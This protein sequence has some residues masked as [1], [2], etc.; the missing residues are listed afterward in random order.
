M[1]LKRPADL[2]LDLKE[3]CIYVDQGKVIHHDFGMSL[4]TRHAKVKLLLGEANLTTWVISSTLSGKS[5]IRQCSYYGE[6]Q[7]CDTLWWTPYSDEHDALH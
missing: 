6:I 4:G 3:A 7:T 5:I 2:A 1:G